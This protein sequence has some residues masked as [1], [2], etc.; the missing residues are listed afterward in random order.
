MAIQAESGGS[1]L[2]QATVDRANAA[3]E[4]A[5]AKVAAAQGNPLAQAKAMIDLNTKKIIAEQ[6]NLTLQSKIA[7]TNLAE[8]KATQTQAQTL[9]AETRAAATALANEIGGTTKVTENG[10]GLYVTPPTVEIT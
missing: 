10:K 7:A 4:A 1:A 9:L 8:T 6:T 3:V 2:T 5:R